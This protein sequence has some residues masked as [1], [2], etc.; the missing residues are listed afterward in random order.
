MLR[1]ALNFAARE[2]R[3]PASVLFSVLT[4]C[5]AWHV[6]YGKNGLSTWLEKRAEDKQLRKEIN[7]LNQE[8]SR[9]RDSIEQL[10]TNPDAI[11]I[12]ARD[13]LHYAKP[14]EVIVNLPPDKQPQPASNVK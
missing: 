1:R 3:L 8:N 12:V 2:W 13:Q 4:V 14:N 6:V 10:K 5:L 11:G 7:D 9:L